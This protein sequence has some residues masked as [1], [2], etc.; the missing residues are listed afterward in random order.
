MGFRFFKDDSSCGGGIVDTG[1]IVRLL[2]TSKQEK[3]WLCLE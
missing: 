1:G 2:Q 3:G